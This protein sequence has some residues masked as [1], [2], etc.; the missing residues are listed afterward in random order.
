MLDGVGEL[1]LEFLNQATQAWAEME[2]NRAV[3]RE[4]G[5]SPVARFAQAPDVLRESPTSNALRDAFRLES[6]RRQRRSDGTISLE[7]VRF[8]LPARY[9]H[10]RDVSVRYARWDLSRVD[11]VD[12][13]TGTILAP[14]YPLD[15]HANAAGQ[16]LLHHH[17]G[18]PCSHP[19]QNRREEAPVLPPSVNTQTSR[20]DRDRMP[21]DYRARSHLSG[22]APS[23]SAG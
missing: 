3:H 1:T 6:S 14:L 19:E 22:Y 20:H 23:S 21:I 18:P 10:F 7:G 5:C 9:R 4:T 17:C 8:E 13:R 12:P 15:R 16:R 11:L 2:Y